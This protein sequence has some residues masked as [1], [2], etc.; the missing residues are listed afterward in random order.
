M[1]RIAI[2]L[3]VAVVASGCSGGDSGKKVT[4]GY[5]ADYNG[6]SLLA[7][8]QQQGLW[9]KHGLK[10]SAKKFTNGPL[11]IQ[12]LG[13]GDLDYG[14]LGP[15]ALWLPASGRAKIVAVNSL[16][17][18]DRLI[19]QP[20]I[21]SVAA[22]KGKKIGVPEGTSGDMIL[23]L[24]LEKAGLSVKDVKKVAMDPSTV[25]SAF[26][27]G[28]IDA[29]GLWYPL[30]DTIKK[31]KP[32]LVELAK[33]AD[34]AGQVSFPTAFVGKNADPTVLKVIQEANDY[35]ATHPD[36][37]VAATAKFLRVP[38]EP[39]KAEAANVKFLPT[40]ELVKDTRDGTVG[41]WLTGIQK[42]FVTFG[43]LP[44]ATDPTSFYTGDQYVQAAQ[45][46]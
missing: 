27:S 35:R 31:R 39:L 25:V 45:A 2:A 13:A 22:L 6:A 37:T 42:L 41:R 23:Q 9:K 7:V 1:K 44:K 14:Y 36:Q 4:F 30:I 18:A 19:A 38:A 46:K 3:V 24:A 20:G 32:N 12:A 26:A 16:G 21:T 15:G 8:A 33:D 17:Y 10:V 29:A 5:N 40:A 11:Q 43:K 34:F 28:Q